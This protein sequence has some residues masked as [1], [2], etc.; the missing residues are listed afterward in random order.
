MTA[1]ASKA[2]KS[3]YRIAD[4]KFTGGATTAKQLPVAGPPEVAFCG[5]SNVGKSSLLN[6]LVARKNLVRTSRTPGC[7]RQIN[8]F[9]V[10]VAA[11]EKFAIRFVDLPGYGYASRAKSERSQWQTMIEGYFRERETWAGAVILVDARRGLEEEEEELAEF[12]TSLN[13]DFELLVVATKIDRLSLSERKP[14]L[15]TV[16]KQLRASKE[17]SLG[18]RVL[19]SSASTGDGR[20]LVWRRLQA[21]AAKK[22]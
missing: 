5:R 10:D 15:A 6:M 8:F 20:D 22:A 7:T 16:E 21:M 11:P 19:G 2:E 4:A 17:K 13:R 14:A 1:A 9:D 3:V 12:L 18:G